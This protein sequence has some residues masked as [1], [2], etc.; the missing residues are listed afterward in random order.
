MVFSLGGVQITLGEH[1][2]LWMVV[3]EVQASPTGPL[4]SSMERVGDFLYLREAEAD[5][6]LGLVGSAG[7]GDSV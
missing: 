1:G 2:R 6:H 5:S 7:L 3:F 4:S